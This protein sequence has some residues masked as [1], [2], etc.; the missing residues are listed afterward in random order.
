MK[1]RNIAFAVLAAFAATA[2]ATGETT[3]QASNANMLDAKALQLLFKM[4]GGSCTWKSGTVEGEDFYYSTVS[5]S[6]GVADRNIG[7]DVMQGKWSL[8]DNQLCTD[9]GTEHCSPLEKVEGKKYKAVWGGK[10]YDLSC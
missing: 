7:A 2:C 8:K 9:F 5:K 4:G 6:M 10:L 3:E 1:I